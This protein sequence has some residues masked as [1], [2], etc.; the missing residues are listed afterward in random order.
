MLLERTRSPL[1]PLDDM[2]YEEFNSMDVVKTVALY[3]LPYL[4]IYVVVYVMY[5]IP[6][7]ENTVAT[8][9]RV[10]CADGF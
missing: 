1:L 4:Y 3:A 6:V 9:V 10:S 7:V 5:L 2:L 8:R